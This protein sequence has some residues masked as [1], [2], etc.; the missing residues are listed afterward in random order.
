MSDT[1]DLS[2][3]VSLIM[4]NPSLVAQIQELA[5]G[6]TK[7]SAATDRP[8]TEPVPASEEA[9][10]IPMPSDT[11]SPLTQREKRAR[12]LSGLKPYLS[13]E[14]RRTIDTMLTFAD[15]L[16]TVRGK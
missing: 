7:E 8:D 9:V 3:I 5:A 12:L 6:K 1:P 13:D 4:E 16:E 10:S 2:K 15:M 11:H 14:R